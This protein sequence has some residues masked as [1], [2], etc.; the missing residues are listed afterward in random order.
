MTFYN[1]STLPLSPRG[2]KWIRRS[3]DKVHPELHGFW[4]NH[5]EAVVSASLVLMIE[6]TQSKVCSTSSYLMVHCISIFLKHAMVS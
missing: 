3:V 2:F 5:Q 6:C 1:A 4:Q